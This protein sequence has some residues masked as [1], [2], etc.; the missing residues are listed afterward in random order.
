MSVYTS[1]AADVAVEALAYSAQILT[2]L[3]QL[4]QNNNK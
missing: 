2:T 3:S 1:E 4:L